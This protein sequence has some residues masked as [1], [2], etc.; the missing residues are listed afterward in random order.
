L[1]IEAT[2]LDE[3][4]DTAKA[5]GHITAGQ[6]ARLALENGVKSLLLTH[7]SRRYRE[8]DVID[9]ARRIFPQTHVARDLDH[10]VI[11]RDRPVERWVAMAGDRDSDDVQSAE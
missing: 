9:E 10:Y 2:F 4:A 6:A 1:V 8:R 11:R 3:D 5:F 7:V